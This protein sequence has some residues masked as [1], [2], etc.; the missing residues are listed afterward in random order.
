MSKHINLSGLKT[1]LEPLIHLINKKAERPDWNENNPNS[2]SYITNRTHYEVMESEKYSFYFSHD[3]DVKSFP[4]HFGL[5]I[6]KEY[7]IIFNNKEYTLTA[8][9]GD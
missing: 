3:H 1:L 2:S 7:T 8:F 5:E 9:I 4:H 6:G